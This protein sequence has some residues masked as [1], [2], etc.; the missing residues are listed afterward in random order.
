MHAGFHFPDAS[1]DYWIPYVWTPRAEPVVV[2]RLASGVSFRAA[3]GD[4]DRILL[5]GRARFLA[6][7]QDFVAQRLQLAGVSRLHFGGCLAPAAAGRRRRRQRNVA[8]HIPAHAQAT[9]SRRT[10]LSGD[11]ARTLLDLA[12]DPTIIVDISGTV[13]FTNAQIERAFG[14]GPAE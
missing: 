5:A 4:V 1:A 14:Y 6:Q 13:V 3:S 2:G 8:E 10:N 7:S 11:L 9:R 12:P